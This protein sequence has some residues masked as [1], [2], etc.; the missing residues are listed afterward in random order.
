MAMEI[1]ASLSVDERSVSARSTDAKPDPADRVDER[2]GLRT[3]DLA[4]DAPDIDVDDVGRR[5]KMQIPYMLQEHRA[6]DHLAGI[7]PEIFEHLEFARQQ[8]DVVVAAP[9]RAGNEVELEIADPQHGL[10]D[11]RAAAAPQRLAPPPQ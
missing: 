2:V 11:H 3:V 10:L 1:S 5:V 6:R 7:A 8:L 9:H 4:P